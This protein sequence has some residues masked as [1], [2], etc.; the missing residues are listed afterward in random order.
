MHFSVDFGNLYHDMVNLN[1]LLF[2]KLRNFINPGII[3]SK[4][5]L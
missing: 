2:C 1:S 3:S 4:F 5:L